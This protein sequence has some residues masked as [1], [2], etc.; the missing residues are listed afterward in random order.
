[1]PNPSDAALNRLKQHQNDVMDDRCNIVH[2]TR[3]SGTYSTQSTETRSMVSGVACGIQF[4]NGQM[5]QGSQVL[6]VDYD[7]VLRLPAS[8][9]IL[10]SDEVQLI[11]KGDYLISGTFKPTS[12]PT[13]SSSVQRVLLKRTVS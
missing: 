11:E 8:Q 6:V 5:R 12:Y 2:I 9:T 13:V 7:A 4:T 3:S 1:M 10:L